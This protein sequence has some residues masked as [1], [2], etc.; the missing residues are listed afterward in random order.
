MHT[1]EI[2][3]VIAYWISGFLWLAI[4]FFITNCYFPLLSSRR[5]SYIDRNQLRC[6]LMG[7][8][9]LPKRSPDKNQM[10]N[11]IYHVRNSLDK[12]KDFQ[13]LWSIFSE[14]LVR[15]SVLSFFLPSLQGC[16]MKID[17]HFYYVFMFDPSP[18][19]PQCWIPRSFEWSK[20]SDGGTWYQSRTSGKSHD[21]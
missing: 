11:G 5:A 6:L 13:L 1:L 14:R 7:D 16:P 12:R 9:L 19:F 3:I 4:E 15:N 18:L 21:S 10:H 20:P 8:E 17:A 2:A